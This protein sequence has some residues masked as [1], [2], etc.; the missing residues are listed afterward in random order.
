[1]GNPTK[2]AALRCIW[3]T[4]PERTCGD[5]MMLLRRHEYA[6]GDYIEAWRAVTAP[7]NWTDEDSK[8]LAPEI[9]TEAA[10]HSGSW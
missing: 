7:D 9:E 5:P 8:R 1:L 4:L 6:V 2:P 10:R 3:P